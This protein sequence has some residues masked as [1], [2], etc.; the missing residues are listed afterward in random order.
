MKKIALI[1]GITGQD[2]SYLAELLL[3]KKYEVHGIVRRS[4]SL[5]RE[6]IEKHY[7]KD[8]YLEGG[9]SK[10]FYLHYGDLSDYSSISNILKKIQPTEIYNLGAQSHVGISFE[11]PIYT[12]DVT[13]VGTLKLLESIKN[14][15]IQC[16]VYQASSSEMFG[17]S[18]MKKQN[19]LTPMS[20]RSPYG[21]SKLFSY[22]ISK[23]YR[24]TY[25]MFISNGILFNHE[26]PRRGENFVTR[27]ITIGAVSI[28]LG[29]QKKLILGNLNSKRDWG[30]AKD[31]VEAMWLMLQ[32]KKPDDFVIATGKS[33]SVKY[34]CE[35]VFDLLKLDYKKYVIS[36]KRYFRP[37]EVD[38]LLGDSSKA[39]KQLGWKA[40]TSIEDLA[41]IMIDAEFKRLKKN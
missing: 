34:F 27:K 11:M 28:K 36:N 16:K 31:Y 35:L 13:G 1:T 39:K 19:E 24:D 12:A 21:I 2:G 15:N 20:P 33:Y 37:L 18:K 9:F 26:S 5:N 23:V 6:R 32:Q 40:K 4:S 17:N 30:Y 3:D 10:K 25:S 41:Q 7:N 8:Q 29:L 38:Y 22:N 14:N